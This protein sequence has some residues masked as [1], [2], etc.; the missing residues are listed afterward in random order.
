[1]LRT[2]HFLLL[3][4]CL[5]TGCGVSQTTGT[6]TGPQGPQGPA[7]PPGLTFRNTFNMVSQYVAT[8]VVTYQGSSYVALATST[9]IVPVG[10]PT[11]ATN[12]AVLAQAGAPGTPGVQGSPGVAGIQGPA[13]PAG[14]TGATGPSGP[15]GPAGPAGATGPA[16]PSGNSQSSYLAG[17]HLGVQGDSISAI[18]QNS[19]QNVVLNR[20]GMTLTSQ[21]A[22]LGRTLP[23]AFECYGVATPGATLGVYHIANAAS[24]YCNNYDG[25]SEGKTL[26]QNLANVDVLIVE[27]GTNDVYETQ[28]AL[29]DP[30]TAGT[31]YGNLRWVCET[32]L[33]A[34]PSIR[35]VL[36]TTQYSIK[37]SPDW[38]KLYADDEEA[39]G[40]SMGI[41]VINMFNLGGVNQFTS[42]TL[43]RDG[44][45]P[46]DF[47][48]A[49][50]YGP[51]IAEQ[52][53]GLY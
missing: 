26:A 9:G 33:T 8:D 50:F 24:G 32:Y 19:W 36:V 51:V 23:E 27:L 11:S 45:H 52:L 44:L 4:L 2:K 38:V 39:Y 28:G 48:F 42:A 15:T 37:S 46:S 47:G 14:Q 20:T 21:D 34:K 16:G 17:R 31:F 43:L 13:G 18:F 30:V 10:S 6:A 35:L 22:R 49:N 3:S 7:G 53:R 1:M 29:G 5:L 25:T 40:K 12:W 41:P